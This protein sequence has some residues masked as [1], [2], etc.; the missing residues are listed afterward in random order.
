M[1]PAP[2]GGGCRVPRGEDLVAGEAQGA[3]GGSAVPAHTA[4]Q[5]ALVFPPRAPGSGRI[6]MRIGSNAIAKLSFACVERG[7]TIGTLSVW[8]YE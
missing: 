8:L 7:G 6:R 5:A 1:G 4:R 3:A 2:R